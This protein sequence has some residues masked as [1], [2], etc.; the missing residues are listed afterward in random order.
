MSDLDDLVNREFDED[1]DVGDNLCPKCGET[2]QY[3]S[4]RGY[5]RFG[6]EQEAD[7]DECPK[8]GYTH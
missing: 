6:Q 7:W 4:M 5:D 1:D 8:C 3:R 2:M